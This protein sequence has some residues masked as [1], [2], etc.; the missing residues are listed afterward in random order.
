[1]KQNE[2]SFFACQFG[3]EEWENIHFIFQSVIRENNKNIKNLCILLDPA[4]PCFGIYPRIFIG[5]M[6]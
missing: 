6:K 1:M 3:K 4:S 5:E 2:K